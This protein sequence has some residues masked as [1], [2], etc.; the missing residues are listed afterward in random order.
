MLKSIGCDEETLK[1]EA[2]SEDLAPAQ[3][4]KQRVA[5]EEWKSLNSKL[6]KLIKDSGTEVIY[7]GDT[8]MAYEIGKQQQPEL[9]LNTS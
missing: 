9:I 7:E 4:E 1:L 2:W 6:E 3:L 8:C 5:E